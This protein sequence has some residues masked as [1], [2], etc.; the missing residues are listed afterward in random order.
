M[1]FLRIAF[2]SAIAA[3]FVLG[4]ISPA[5]NEGHHSHPPKIVADMTWARSTPA[6][7]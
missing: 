4:A 6:M 2:G 7:P 1:S 3:L 5:V